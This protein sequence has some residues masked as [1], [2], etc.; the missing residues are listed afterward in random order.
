MPAKGLNAEPVAARQR[1]QWQFSAY[2]NWSATRYC[3]APH[4]HLPSSIFTQLSPSANPAS[5]SDAQHVLLAAER[6]PVRPRAGGSGAAY[7]LIAAELALHHTFAACQ[8]RQLEPELVH[9]SGRDVSSDRARRAVDG[10]R[11]R[12]A[13]EPRQGGQHMPDRLRR[14]LDRE[15]VD[16]LAHD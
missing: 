3:T 7:G 4:S 2:R 15:A 12:N 1:E 5:A 8:R 16:R 14:R 13:V 10:W 11:L 6:V 9:P